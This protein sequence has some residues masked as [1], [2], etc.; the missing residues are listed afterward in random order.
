MVPSRSGRATIRE[1]ETL[2]SHWHTLQRVT[3]DLLRHDGQIQTLA[4]EAYDRGDSVAVLAYCK[5]RASVILVKQFRLPALVGGHPTGELI[6]V[7]AGIIEGDDILNTARKEVLEECKL[8]VSHIQRLATLYIN[9]AAMTERVHLCL[10]EVAESLVPVPFAGVESEGEDI[11]ILEVPLI[12]AR[13]WVNQG[14]IVDAKSVL[15][16]LYLFAR[17]GSLFS[18]SGVT[19]V[20]ESS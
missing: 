2:S 9:P 13:D 20:A 11:E 14:L 19:N 18:N 12:T 3:F 17:E 1:I 15:L 10:A 6:E 8:A 16:L 4:R 7:V 5:E